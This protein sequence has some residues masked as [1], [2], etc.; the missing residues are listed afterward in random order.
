MI[1]TTI[2][3]PRYRLHIRLV[4]SRKRAEADSILPNLATLRSFRTG[5]KLSRVLR[6]ILERANIKA[7]LGGNL[8][9]FV[10]LSGLTPGSATLSLSEPALSEPEITTLDLR[11]Q[12]LTTEVAI[13]YPVDPVVLNQSYHFFHWGIDLDG[14]TGDPI[15][16]IMR[17]KVTK[18]EHSRFAYGNSVLIDHENGVQSLYAHLDEISVREGDEVQTRSVIGKMGSTGRSTGDHLHLEVYKNNKP[19]NP[20]SVLP[21][22][23]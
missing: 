21:R 5:N 10:M 15:R 20:V 11:E 8:A 9:L 13:Q 18:T 12:T 22:G 19:V 6:H 1:N 7:F 4:K 14:V 3:L 16:P 23:R 17:G 2:N